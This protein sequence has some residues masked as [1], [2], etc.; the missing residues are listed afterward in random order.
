MWLSC[1]VVFGSRAARCALLR[2]DASQV[3][4]YS[5]NGLL[6]AL[7]GPRVPL[8]APPRPGAAKLVPV[9]IHDLIDLKSQTTLPLS[10]ELEASITNNQASRKS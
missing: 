1:A 9:S 4:K 8:V 2:Q 10:M 5:D 3:S 7:R 6:S